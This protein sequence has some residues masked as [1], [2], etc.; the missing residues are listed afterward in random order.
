M[1]IS[2]SF[3][4]GRFGTRLQ[5]AE[6]PALFLGCHMSAGRTELFVFLSPWGSARE[7]GLA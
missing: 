2:S 7:P 4:L 5:A 3:S 1:V 6:H